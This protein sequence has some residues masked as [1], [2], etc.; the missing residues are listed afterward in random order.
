[1]ADCSSTA[2]VAM[3]LSQRRWE[4]EEQWR[5]RVKAARGAY[6]HVSVQYVRMVKE[7][8]HGQIPPTDGCFAVASARRA[9]AWALNEFK[10]IMRVYTDLVLNGSIPTAEMLPS[11]PRSVA[12]IT[13]FSAF[14]DEYSMRTRPRL[15]RLALRF[16]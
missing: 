12:S 15:R 1:M 10:R 13:A 4:L 14:H 9:E 16:I 5:Q 11:A 3:A 6:I 8:G 7:L 2:E